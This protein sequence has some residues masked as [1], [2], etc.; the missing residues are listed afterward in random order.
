MKVLLPSL[1]LLG[2]SYWSLSRKESNTKLYYISLA[3][4]VTSIFDSGFPVCLRFM[5]PTHPLTRHK[6]IGVAV[7]SVVGS[8]TGALIERRVMKAQGK[9]GV[10][11]FCEGDDINI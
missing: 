5:P 3:N 9:G 8:I 4:H 10:Y 7:G 6:A 11:D 2:K 1:I